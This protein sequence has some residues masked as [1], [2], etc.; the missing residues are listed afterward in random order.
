MNCSKNINSFPKKKKNFF[1]RSLLI[2]VVR[3][4]SGLNNRWKQEDQFGDIAIIQ[5]RKGCHSELLRGG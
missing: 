1:K 4:D 5:A 2:A 3:R